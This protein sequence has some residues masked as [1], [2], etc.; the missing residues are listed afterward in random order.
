[1]KTLVVD[2]TEQRSVNTHKRPPR[3]R[4]NS[5]RARALML[6][7]PTSKLQ[8]QFQELRRAPPIAKA[9][10][11]T[12]CAPAGIPARL[13]T[14]A[15]AQFISSSPVKLLSA[16]LVCLK[17]SLACRLARASAA[18]WLVKTCLGSWRLAV[19][20]GLVHLKLMPTPECPA[21]ER[22]L[23]LQHEAFS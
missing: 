23:V 16:E 14:V 18:F 17:N 21:L 4:I 13:S 19:L 20:A 11:Q 6:S 5:C 1:M 7:T 2:W 3:G 10:H 8:K 15:A 12:L 9:P 22:N